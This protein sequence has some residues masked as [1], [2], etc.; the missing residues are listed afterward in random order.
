MIV[1]SGTTREAIRLFKQLER[2]KRK[3]QQLE[4][5]L[6]SY[7]KK[8]PEDEIPFYLEQAE[9]IKKKQANALEKFKVRRLQRKYRL[10][11]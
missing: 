4:I 9:R 6:E 5:Q 7:V 3:V 1:I 10:G 2:T 8:I 11:R